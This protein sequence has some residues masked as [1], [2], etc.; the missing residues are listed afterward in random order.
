MLALGVLTGCVTGCLLWFLKRGRLPVA[1][2]YICQVNHI[3][4]LLMTLSVGATGVGVGALAHIDWL[5]ATGIVVGIITALANLL[6]WG[7][8]QWGRVS[9]E[10]YA[11]W[12]DQQAAELLADA[13]ALAK[14]KLLLTQANDEAED[15]AA[16]R[17]KERSQLGAAQPDTRPDRQAGGTNLD[18]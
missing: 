16:A 7:Y 3:P 15:H 18:V 9:R 2:K 1:G 4:H 6:F 11:A 12:R 14:S 8:L 10:R 5:A 17:L 13:L